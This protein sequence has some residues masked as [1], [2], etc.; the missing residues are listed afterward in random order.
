MIKIGLVGCGTWG[1]NY[2]KT[3]CSI[4]EATIKYI[5]DVKEESLQKAGKT[6]SS[7][8]KTTD[9]HE[10]LLDDQLDGVIITT[11][12]QSHFPIAA[13]FLSRKK[14]VLVEKP[15]TLSY[16]EADTLIKLAAKNNTV[17]M[18]GHLMEYHPA[19]LK[20]QEYINQGLLGRLRY[21]LLERTGLGD[22]RHEVSVHWDLS[23]HDFS[24]VRYL[25]DQDPIW[26]SA[27][28]ESY[29][30]PNVYDLVIITMKFPGD[31]LVQIQ[32]NCIS[33]IKK[34]HAE[35]SGEQMTMAFDDVKNTNGIQL[36]SN[37]G[38]IATAKFEKE[39]PLT[40]Q[41]LHFLDCIKTKAL[42]RTGSTDILWVI[43]ATELAEQSFLNHGE[44]L[45]WDWH[46][47]ISVNDREI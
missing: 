1:F 37:T 27:H 38:E 12:P 46:G 4:P 5:C 42:P 7:I 36:I 11:P 35:I 17:L 9:Y 30:Q 41:C 23:V 32:T 40:K 45:Y 10:L 13:D 24:I 25:V 47:D 19:V 15:C 20:M 44:R 6:N 8:K 33:L 22:L 2:I 31:L 21:I 18:V 3:L 14:A 39:L 34:R 43:K 29:Q 16:H 28:G 26:I